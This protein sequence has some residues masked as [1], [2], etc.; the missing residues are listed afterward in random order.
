M[1]GTYKNCR[2]K[3]WSC[4]SR[5]LQFTVLY[6]FCESKSYSGLDEE[7]LEAQIMRHRL[8]EQ[9]NIYLP[10]TIYSD[11]TREGE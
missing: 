3:T 9:N 6:N 4:S 7:D 10:K 2:F 11:N 1:E 8:E 5:S